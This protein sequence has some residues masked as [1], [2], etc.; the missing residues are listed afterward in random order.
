[1]SIKYKIDI[2]LDSFERTLLHKEIILSKPFL[3]NLYQEW[4]TTFNNELITLPPGK[5][6]ELGS[7]GGFLKELIPTVISSDILPLPS[8]DMTFSALD[9]PFDNDSISG[10]FMVD[11]FHHLPDIY[12]FLSEADRVLIKNGK[13]IMIEPANSLWGRFIYKH[14]HHEPFNP[15]GKWQSPNSGP[16]SGANGSLPW[17]VFVR[18]KQ[19]FS[20]LFPELLVNSIEYHTPFR[21]LLSGGVSFKQI[22][23]N[24]SFAFFSK[25]DH[26][27]TNLSSNIS[28]F[29]TIKLSKI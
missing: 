20:K 1:M 5:I 25:F 10:L 8:N 17:I 19:Y 27:L 7:G 6:V 9:M 14:F 4:Y 23:P 21:Y 2:P 26:W 12:Q 28:M 3:K 11:T 29:M 16:M 22:V 18:D 24:K 13:I 15:K